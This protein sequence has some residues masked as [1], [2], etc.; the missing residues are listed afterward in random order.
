MSWTDLLL[1]LLTGTVLL[2]IGVVIAWWTHR[3]RI[4]AREAKRAQHTVSGS[5]DMLGQRE[6]AVRQM[7]R[8]DRIVFGCLVDVASEPVMTDRL[9][10]DDTDAP[11]EVLGAPGSGKSIAALSP[12]IVRH[13]GP[14]LVS[15]TK[16]DL[17][18]GTIGARAIT[19]APVI[20]DPA[21]DLAKSPALRDQVRVWTPITEGVTWARAQRTSHAMLTAVKGAEQGGQQAFFVTHSTIVVAAL[22]VYLRARPGSSLL[23]LIKQVKK[24]GGNNS[25]ADDGPDAWDS[26]LH[27]LEAEQANYADAAELG[28]DAA[29]T[30]SAALEQA[31]LALGL[32]A[33]AAR[34]EETRAG[35][36]GS[37]AQVIEGL[38][39]AGSV[40]RQSWDDKTT[41]RLDTMPEM[42]T[43]YL[44]CPTPDYR[45]LTNALLGAY[46]EELQRRASA[47][48]GALPVQHLVV[49]DELVHCTPHRDLQSW[50]ANLARSARVK[51]LL[52]T[53]SVSDLIG[54]YGR[55]G[56]AS[57]RNACSGGHVLFAATTDSETLRA[58]SE[59]AGKRELV[60]EQSVSISVTKSNN[61]SG[62]VKGMLRDGSS[63]SKTTQRS[64][65]LVEKD[66]ATPAR[67][68]A[69]Q[70][71]HALVW[72]PGRPDVPGGTVQVRA[73]PL[74]EDPDLMAAAQGDRA[75]LARVQRL[76]DTSA[77][78]TASPG[79]RLVEEEDELGEAA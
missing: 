17:A 77:W 66:A 57:I 63:T 44:I 7:T 1:W 4:A 71:F 39:L 11:V 67:L 78:E 64:R 16:T 15:T 18:R 47:H 50:A 13:R 29:V 9:V 35:I 26:L 58:Y 23:D 21:A 42:H 31:Q 69:M 61:Y 14:A 51:F 70:T 37:V 3:R 46:V 53:Q 41:L 68:A 5:R 62:A 36:L 48:G 54:V 45:P 28:E 25:G 65:N 49:L 72:L 52:C 8:E 12:A 19:T 74:F 79:P 56:A 30:M 38:I 33:A 40:V 6:I 59:L 43:L 20:F 24:L 2:C 22:L 32:T 55:E 27:D 60:Q 75:A 10:M 34:A 76:P 73:T